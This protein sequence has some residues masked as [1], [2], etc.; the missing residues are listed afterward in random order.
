MIDSLLV[1]LSFMKGAYQFKA[2][3]GDFILFFLFF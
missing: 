3:H 1:S 2:R